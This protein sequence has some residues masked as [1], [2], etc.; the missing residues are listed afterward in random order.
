MINLSEL[1]YKQLIELEKQIQKEKE[2]KARD[3]L[4]KTDLIYDSEKVK[5]IVSFLDP[6]FQHGQYGYPNDEWKNS[7]ADVE[8]FESKSPEDQEQLLVD[9]NRPEVVRDIKDKLTRNMLY[10]CDIALENY[11]DYISKTQSGPNRGEP[12]SKYYTISTNKEIPWQKADQ[13]KSMYNE[14][15]DIF[16]KYAKGESNA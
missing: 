7:K 4:T 12:K 10:M 11:R 13:Y 16:L 14:L 1:N 2:K 9:W 6:K 5:E 8:Y 15:C 3:Y